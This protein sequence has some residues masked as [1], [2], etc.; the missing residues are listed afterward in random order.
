MCR[1]SRFGLLQEKVEEWMQAIKVLM[2]KDLRNNPSLD[3]ESGTPFSRN[4]LLLLLLFV[5]VV[6]RK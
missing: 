3:F 2:Q 5:S 6:L 4:F 1:I